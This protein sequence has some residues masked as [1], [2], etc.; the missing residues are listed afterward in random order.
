MS[1]T[2]VLYKMREEEKGPTRACFFTLNQSFVAHS[3][4]CFCGQ[5]ILQAQETPFSTP[6][7]G[8]PIGVGFLGDRNAKGKG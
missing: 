5:R 7:F 3:C 1:E 2:N 8:E 4:L 6:G